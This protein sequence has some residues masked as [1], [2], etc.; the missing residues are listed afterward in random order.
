MRRTAFL[1]LAF[2]SLPL[3]ADPQVIQ[4]DSRVM[5]EKRTILVSLP[6]SYGNGAH[7]YPVLYMTDGDAQL[8]HTA[9]TV[10]FLARS[11][12]IPEMIVVG[13]NNTDRTRDLTPTHVPSQTIEGRVFESPSSGGADRFLS[14]IETEVIPTI[15]QRYRTE[16]YRVF[17]GHSFGG[18]FAMHALFTKP[19]LFNAWIAVS[20]SL[21]WDGGYV[22]RRAKE[23]SKSTPQLDGTL[24]FTLGDEPAIA[25]PA[26]SLRK[27]LRARGPKG[28]E[29]EMIVYR[30]EDHGSVVLPSHY[31]AL[32]RIFDAWRFAMPNDVD[33]RTLYARA[34]QHFA[35]VSKRAGYSLKVPEHITNLI[36]YRLLGAGLTSQAI[37]VFRRN[38]E[39]YP[40]SANVYDSLGEALERKGDLDEAHR[41]YERAWKIGRDTN[42]VNA[43]IYRRN[44]ER[45]RKAS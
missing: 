40:L 1:V 20:P 9:E 8:S 15:E 22:E 26:E 32:R 35:H 45:T 42:D 13:I 29:V 7:A 12:R 10:R 37:D 30:D 11:A 3:F 38:V 5:G 23:F 14:F 33:P 44:F 21:N 41:A 31:A 36:G 4:L 24:V 43:E 2:L 28:L 25:A 34:E 19:K 6:L 39:T 18:L 16:P 27:L 17:A